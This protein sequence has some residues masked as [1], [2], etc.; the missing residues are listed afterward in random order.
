MLV[1]DLWRDRDAWADLSVDDVRDIMG[2]ATGVVGAVPFDTVHTTSNGFVAR[3]LKGN[4]PFNL[5]LTW[6]FR[7]TLVSDVLIPLNFCIPSSITMLPFE[8]D[9]YTNI[10]RFANL[11][12]TSMHD[13]PRV[14]DLNYLFNLL[15]GVVE[16]QRRLLG[17]AGWAH[18]YFAKARLLNVWRTVPF[19]DVPPVLDRFEKHGIPMCLDGQ[20]TTPGGHD[21]ETFVEI[22]QLE[23]IELDHARVIL[24]S[25]ALF[26][27]IARAYGVPSWIEHNASNLAEPYYD[28]LQRA[29]YRAMEVQRLRNERNRET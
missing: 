29:G 7:P 4:N 25:L 20:V 2:E 14:V 9:G 12:V 10:K 27:P 24:Q 28:E 3:Q 23:D 17:K 8:M 6:R 16:I 19:L 1:A 18:S 13:R 15:I 11:L 21:P 22:D 26:A 5:G